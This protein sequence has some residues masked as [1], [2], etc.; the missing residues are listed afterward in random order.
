MPAIYYGDEGIESPPIWRRSRSLRSSTLAI[1]T[2]T[3]TP[4]RMG[5]RGGEVDQSGLVVYRRDRHGRNLMAADPLCARCRGRS[6]A[7]HTQTSILIA[8]VRCVNGRDQ[9]LLPIGSSP[10]ALASAAGIAQM[11]WF[12]RCIAPVGQASRRRTLWPPPTRMV[13]AV[14]ACARHP[15]LKRQASGRRSTSRAVSFHL[16]AN[17]GLAVFATS[18]QDDLSSAHA[19]PAPA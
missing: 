6:E 12:E 1:P 10:W 3:T 11:V 14:V 5:K 8:Q 19:L 9:R 16:L 13:N 4:R 15:Q 18:I 17:E 7:A 2:T